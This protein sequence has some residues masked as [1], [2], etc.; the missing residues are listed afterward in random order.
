MPSGASSYSGTSLRGVT[1]GEA[2]LI[3]IVGGAIAAVLGAGLLRLFSKELSAKVWRVL[4]TP[5]TLRITTAKRQRAAADKL[6]A[7][8]KGL[9]SNA[10]FYA[11]LCEVLGVVMLSGDKQLIDRVRQL[12]EKSDLNEKRFKEVCDLL[13]VWPVR[14]DSTVVPERIAALREAKE[15]AAAHAREQIEATQS[16]A[17]QQLADQ[18][19]RAAELAETARELG[20][21]EGHAQAMAEVE[22]QRAAPLLRPVWRALRVD[23]DVFQLKNTQDGILVTDVQDVSLEVPLRDFVFHGSNQWP[24]FFPGEVTFSG[25]LAGAGKRFGANLVIRWRDANGDH[26]HGE[27]LVPPAPRRAVVL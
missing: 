9:Q 8:E 16:L 4:R 2:W 6:K 18:T 21:S 5:L 24:G 7:A 27:L 1:S 11:A 10:E 17:Q 14:E 25:E 20:R 23:E 12:R 26:R 22:A 15:L 13:E 3:A 19:R